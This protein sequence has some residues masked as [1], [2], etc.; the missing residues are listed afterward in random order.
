MFFYKCKV[1][2][3]NRSLLVF[4]PF[5]TKFHEKTSFSW[6]VKDFF[7]PLRLLIKMALKQE[8]RIQK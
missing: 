8:Y 2:N 1:N 7:V 3:K 4:C 6:L 5:L